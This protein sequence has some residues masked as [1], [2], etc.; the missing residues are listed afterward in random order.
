MGSRSPASGWPPLPSARRRRAAGV[1]IAGDGHDRGRRR[2]RIGRPGAWSLALT[3]TPPARRPIED[4]LAAAGLPP[5]PRTAWLEI[6]LD[7]LAGNLAVARD[8][9]GPNILVEPV[10]KADAYGHGMVPVARALV[11]AGADGL[12][13]ATLDEAVA[14]RDAGVSCRVTV[15]YPVPPALAPVAAER[16]IAVAAGEPSLL[17]GLLAAVGDARSGASTSSSRSRRVWGVVVHA[18]MPRWTPHARS[19]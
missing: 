19:P 5:L 1:R 11:E 9:A 4:R 3:A 14:L 8:L 2:R 18:S 12:C 10:V 17:A 13:V 6:D 16:S 7:A 15:L